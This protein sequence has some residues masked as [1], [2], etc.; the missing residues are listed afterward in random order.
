MSRIT[1]LLLL[2]YFNARLSYGEYKRFQCNKY[3]YNNKMILM[4]NPL[5]S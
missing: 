1:I 4:K 3:S 5:C 2:T